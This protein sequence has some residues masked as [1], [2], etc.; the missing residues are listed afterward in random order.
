MEEED[1]DDGIEDDD[2]EID[3]DNEDEKEELEDGTEEDCEEEEEEEE[4][5]HCETIIQEKQSPAHNEGKTQHYHIN[6]KISYNFIFKFET[7]MQF[8]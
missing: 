6:T 4:E 8:F 3:C 1:V 7:P 5:E 2:E